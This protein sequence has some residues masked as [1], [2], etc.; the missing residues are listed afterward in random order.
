MKTL[1]LAHDFDETSER[2][3]DTAIEL[4]RKLPAKVVVSH[5]YSVPVYTFPEGSSLIPSAEDASRL[6]EAAQRSLDQVLERRRAVTDVEISGTLR[7]GV[8]D[9]EICRLADEIGADMIVIGTHTRGAVARALLGSVAQRVVR[10]A[11]VPV[12]TIRGPQSA[13]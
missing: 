2:A 8:P 9:E 12:L 3:L 4:A 1:L 11:K 13:A 5:V 7:A 6:A 10:T